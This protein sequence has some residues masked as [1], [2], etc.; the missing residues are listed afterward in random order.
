MQTT[1]HREAFPGLEFAVKKKSV[2]ANTNPAG[3]KQMA[4]PRGRPATSGFGWRYVAGAALLALLGT[5]IA[6]NSNAAA[7]AL[8][9]VSPVNSSANTLTAQDTPPAGNI[10]R[11]T[12]PA[13]PAAGDGDDAGGDAAAPA[14]DDS[15]INTDLGSDDIDS[16]VPASAIQNGAPIVAPPSDIRPGSFTLEAR[17]T[18]DGPPLGDD[19][20]WRIFGDTPDADGKLKLLGE[21][22]GGIIY[23]RLDPGTYYV[24]AAYGRA[25]TTRKI[26]VSEPTGG[27]VLVLNAGG[28]RLLA[29]NGKDQPLAQG[30]VTF[31]V[32]A[33]DEGGSDE[34]FL[35]VPNA[36]PGHVIS[37]NA[38]TYHV[39]SK[40]GDAN[41]V[42]RTD[43]KIDPGKLTEATMFQKAAKLT[44][45]L[46]E[47]HG[48][49]A[50]ADTAWTVTTAD[51]DAVAQS[52]GAFPSVVLAIGDYIAIAK[53][54]S[55]SYRAAF[56]VE[57]GTDHDVEVLAQ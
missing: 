35:L 27:E 52:V 31:D 32:Y 36:P 51:G 13:A 21:A 28:M 25:G 8:N 19:V 40:Y 57:A 17:L 47:Q 37:L 41:A 30:Q 20:K 22:N 26:N 9:R 39:V 2:V 42:V 43:I 11:P 14:A 18:N 34:Q 15:G 6:E 1:A 12:L 4:R 54:D 44:L 7:L 53:H 16:D 46:V 33:P 23:V 50:I 48:G 29:V 10:V 45:K 56:R 5:A 55:K 49:E 38:G 24:H 3:M